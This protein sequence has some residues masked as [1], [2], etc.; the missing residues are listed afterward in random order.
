M[1]LID[2][3]TS[4][5]GMCNERGCGMGG[6]GSSRR[7]LYNFSSFFSISSLVY[8]YLFSRLHRSCSAGECREA[9]LDLLCFYFSECLVGFLPM[10][11]KSCVAGEFRHESLHLTG[12]FYG[13]L[14]NVNARPWPPGRSSVS[15]RAVI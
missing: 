5:L 12:L 10:L 11:H 13:M 2:L 14:V 7:E 9:S 3:N 8:L 15:M 4:G 1:L 6:R